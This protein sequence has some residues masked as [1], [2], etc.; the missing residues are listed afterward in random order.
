MKLSSLVFAALALAV[1]GPALADDN[2]QQNKMKACQA[3]A[4]ERKL[5]GKDRQA[6]V[7]ECLK[8]APAKKES[9]MAEC[10]RRTAGLKGDERKK[11]QSECMKAS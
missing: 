4:G 6:F 8:A 1:T 9:R 7:N 5:E 2:P 3:Q 10:N 11:M